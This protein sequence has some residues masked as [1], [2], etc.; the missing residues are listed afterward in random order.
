MTRAIKLFL[1]ILF[2]SFSLSLV[3][4]L[5][6]LLA[7][8]SPS[9]LSP[10]LPFRPSPYPFTPH[11]LLDP[12]LQQEVLSTVRWLLSHSGFLFKPE[13]AQIITGAEEGIYLWQALRYASQ[14]DDT[15]DAI[16]SKREAKQPASSAPTSTPPSTSSPSPSSTTQ[17]SSPSSPSSSS[18]SLPSS[19]LSPLSYSLGVLELG[20]ASMQAT[21]PLP[22]PAK[23][24]AQELTRL[25]KT[26]ETQ[27]RRIGEN[28]SSSCTTHCHTN[29]N[30]LNQGQQAS[31]LSSS[32][33][34]SS[35][36]SSPSASSSAYSPSPPSIEPLT[37]SQASVELVPPLLASS[38][39]PPIPVYTV[40]YPEL[41]LTRAYDRVITLSIA[42]L[43][44]MGG[45]PCLVPS[46]LH[47]TNIKSNHGSG[48][49][50]TKD[51]NPNHGI[52]V[53]PT[54]DDIKKTKEQCLHHQLTDNIK[55]CQ[56]EVGDGC[57]SKK[58]STNG[59]AIPT[60]TTTSASTSALQPQPS[61]S[62]SNTNKRLRSRRGGW[63]DRP[64]RIK[65]SGKSVTV[66]TTAA[67]FVRLI[68]DASHNTESCDAYV[69]STTTTKH[70]STDSSTLNQGTESTTSS[71]SQSS[72]T[73]SSTSSPPSSSPA[74]CPHSSHSASFP[75]FPSS[76]P[77]HYMDVRSIGLGDYER[78][79]ELIHHFIDQVLAA[80]DIQE[81]KIDVLPASTSSSSPPQHT[82]TKLHDISSS[83]SSPSSSPS[84]PPQPTFQVSQSIPLPPQLPRLST[85]VN[86]IAFEQDNTNNMP[87]SPEQSQSIN[88][89]TTTT[90]ETSQHNRDRPQRNRNTSVYKRD[91]PMLRLVASENFFHPKRHLL[92]WADMLVHS[93]PLSNRLQTSS[94]LLNPPS[95][96]TTTTATPA[97]NPPHVATPSPSP[98]PSPSP[99]APTS[100]SLTPASISSPSSLTNELRALKQEELYAGSL[101]A[102]DVCVCEQPKRPTRSQSTPPSQYQ[103]QHQQTKPQDSTGSNGVPTSRNTS[104]G[105]S[106][107]NGNGSPTEL[108]LLPTVYNEDANALVSALL[109]LGP[110]YCAT[111]SSM[112][113]MFS[114]TAHTTTSSNKCFAA[115]YVPV[116]L[117]RVVG[118]GG[119]TRQYTKVTTTVGG[120]PLE[121]ALGGA[122]AIL[123]NSYD[124]FK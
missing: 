18:S 44:R 14:F 13:W 59:K 27:G 101:R 37:P 111:P 85:L 106:N 107:G 72:S 19:S 22:F 11:R 87:P 90:K 71:T 79:V 122:S 50:K 98:S 114:H 29:H 70:N 103:H 83:S 46:R 17:S 41:G 39:D 45:N 112:P 38:G 26:E 48:E 66:T 31:S 104:G 54:Q 23:E 51:P 6:F 121:W 34:G 21:I 81:K 7:P 118:L 97:I 69:C 76:L 60:S 73:S 42:A 58:A 88:T 1:L 86:Y 15:T 10:H 74:Q 82:D 12:S 33:S 8:P 47:D 84:S 124:V 9:F 36:S 4:F 63:R 102:K 30:H 35:S 105:S 89:T 91:V 43:E 62:N 75:S 40:S 24:V 68:R 93:K 3:F 108:N 55:P 116:L 99:P 113:T 32:S 120:W 78:C 5:S 117:R 57:M 65:G 100:P 95:T 25:R 56:K 28:D 96:T 53:I 94:A 64:I 67:Q 80:D 49:D 20:G 52:G 77:P 2:L 115:A 109:Q 123:G 16:Q 119:R 61:I 110:I 92:E